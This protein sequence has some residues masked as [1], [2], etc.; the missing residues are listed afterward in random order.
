M[1]GLQPDRN[2]YKMVYLS[3]FMNSQA[4]AAKYPGNFQ[5]RHVAERLWGQRSWAKGAG[6]FVY[7]RK[8]GT[9]QLESLK[10]LAEK[11]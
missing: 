5:R 2:E 1:E 8:P 11:K 6:R 3:R 10:R 9:V 7:V 4:M